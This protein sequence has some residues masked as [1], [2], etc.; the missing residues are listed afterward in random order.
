MRKE[1]FP[2]TLSMINLFFQKIGDVHTL[3]KYDQIVVGIMFSGCDGKYQ[4]VIFGNFAQR[5]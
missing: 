4:G 2:I 3:G 1:I 5:L